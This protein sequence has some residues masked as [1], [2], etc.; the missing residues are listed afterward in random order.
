M[1][2]TWEN[3]GISCCQEEGEGNV[4]CGYVVPDNT[5][6]FYKL[7]IP[8]IR[9]RALVENIHVHSGLNSAEKLDNE[10]WA[11]GFDMTYIDEQPPANYKQCFR[12]IEE[13]TKETNRLAEQLKCPY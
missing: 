5:H 9:D 11:V 4:I 1:K 6:P 3:S 10:R 12:T 7:D 13:C 8:E 2:I